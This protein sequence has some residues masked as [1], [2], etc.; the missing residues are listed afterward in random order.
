MENI[1]LVLSLFIPRI[2]LIIFYFMHSIPFNNVPLIGD[3][4]L[5]IFLP[6]VLILIYIVENF[7]VDSPWFWIHLVMAVLVYL[8]G[9][10]KISKR[11]MRKKINITG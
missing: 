4:L 9:G 11:R 5:A 10:K 7:G 3:A 8:F 6:R 2:T 1:F